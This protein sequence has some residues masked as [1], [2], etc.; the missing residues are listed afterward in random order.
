MYS[1]TGQGQYGSYNSTYA[2]SPAAAVYNATVQTQPTQHTPALGP[3]VGATNP[4]S[5]YASF[6]NAAAPTASPYAAYANPTAAAA[7]A[8]YGQTAAAVASLQQ[9]QQQ[10]VQQNYSNLQ[11]QA[12]AATGVVSASAAAYPGHTATR[13]TDSYSTV[14]SVPSTGEY[15]NTLRTAAAAAVAAS[16]A[17]NPTSNNSYVGVARIGTTVTSQAANT[18]STTG[19]SSS[20]SNYNSYDA[21]V[22]A[23][24]SSY[25]Q[26]K[27]VGAAN[28][29]MGTTKKSATTGYDGGSSSFSG[30]TSSNIAITGGGGS[31]G[32]SGRGGYSGNRGR[33][34]FSNKRFG[35]G[36]SA[37]MQQFYCEVC[38]ISCAGAQTYKEHMDGQKHKKKEAMQKGEGQTLSKSR[39]SFR[40][41]TCNVTC[42]GKDTYESHVRGSK[43]QKTANLMKKLGKPVAET[44]TV[45]A[46]GEK[47][48]KPGVQT[49]GTPISTVGG[50]AVPTKRVIG[51]STVKFVGGE[52]LQSGTQELAR[53]VVNAEAAIEASGQKS[54]AVEAALAAEKE[55][56][57][58]GEDYVEEERNASGKLIQYSCK[59]CDCK[60]SDPNAKNIHI[61]GR[62]HRLQYKMKVNPNLVVEVK[63]NQVP[64]EMRNEIAR[65]LRA[66]RMHVIPPRPLGAP[67]PLLMPLPTRPWCGIMD[68]GRRVET[69]EDRHVMAKHRLIYPEESQL[70]AIEKL[71][72]IT[73]K[74]LK[75]VSD[76]L[77][78]EETK[79]PD[80]EVKD[81][82]EDEVTLRTSETQHP[83]RILKGVMRVGLLAK[84][85]LL[86]TDREV[87]LVVLCSQPPTREL[88]S[89]VVRLLPQVI[90]KGENEVVTVVEKPEESALLLKHSNSDMIC[91]VVL[92][93]VLLREEHAAG[94]GDGAT[95][96]AGAKATPPK[97]PLPKVPCLEALA[98]LRHAKWFQ[99]RCSN[100][101]SA[102]ITLRILRDVRQR[103][104]TWQPL[105]AWMTEL[106]VEKVLSSLG[107]PLSPGDAVRRVFEAVASGILFSS[108]PG[109]ID[110]CEKQPV[111]VLAEL[112]G[113][114]REDITS[115]SQH[116]LRL[117]AF[118]QMYKVLAIDRLPDIRNSYGSGNN[119]NSNAGG[120]VSNDRKR[121]RDS[122]ASLDDGEVAG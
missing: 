30:I 37:D 9:Q 107:A 72:S 68:P 111:D 8:Q 7:Y 14:G 78:Q 82:Q 67:Q 86:K 36:R 16:A 26:S 79:K 116:A 59:L 41:E 103:V 56:Q 110:P 3:A 65:K 106:L 88:L 61:K 62:K 4:T 18:S 24:A 34:T 100:L 17:V 92:T 25:L 21:A 44:P 95:A 28:I 15:T 91:R 2:T 114:Q 60:F 96:A 80:D 81:S 84:G 46:P 47:S 29:W 102:T 40:C 104:Q 89:K 109:L 39:V 113:Q 5:V 99:V 93:C 6:S 101:H 85:L 49:G 97:D 1:F 48:N 115:S 94:E 57:P 122:N 31:G 13:L 32:I 112:T 50:P 63:P 120:N 20:T 55:V 45:L 10:Q 35:Q 52:K 66:Q 71:V 90:E 75:A 58:V 117:I 19:T 53:R 70:S 42:T 119:G 12:A 51:V 118:N 22:Y 76:N 54:A 77:A 121:P 74:A 108:G 38:K 87:Q 43:H 73:E 83:D 64:R 11:L 33:G 27:A 23:A 105:R 69:V 98:E